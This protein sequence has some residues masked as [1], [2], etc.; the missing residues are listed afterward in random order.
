M[1]TTRSQYLKNLMQLNKEIPV[2]TQKLK[3]MG[4]SSFLARKYKDNGWIESLGVGAFKFP[5]VDLTIE[6]ILHALQINLSLNIY[7]GA[8][9]ALEI[10]G[11]RQYYREKEKI[12]LYTNSKTY[13]PLWA[14]NY[15][16]N[17]KLRVIRSSKWDDEEFLVNPNTKNF[18]FFIASKELAIV[19]QIE[20]VGRGESFEETAQL[21]ELLDSMDP[22]LLNKVLQKA[23]KRS[24]RIFKFFSDFY[25][26]PW[27]KYMNKKILNSGNSVITVEK[28]GRYLHQYELI[29]PKSFNV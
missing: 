15:K 22:D 14:K 11:V 10:A 13:L 27:N 7:P 9:T 26:H 12:Y 5:N 19:Q 20:L 4:I 18:E 25:K 16:Y 3:K 2:I 17:K 23:S 28:G 8:K 21:F 24:R 6:G 1:G 29:I